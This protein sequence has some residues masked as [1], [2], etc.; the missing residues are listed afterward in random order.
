MKT[1][2]NHDMLQREGLTVIEL[3]LTLATVAVVAFVG[4]AIYQASQDVVQIEDPISPESQTQE[5]DPTEGIPEQTTIEDPDDLDEAIEELERID[6]Q[7][8]QETDDIESELEE[9]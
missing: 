5:S 9:L 6:F 1:N 2:K 3:V 4:F 7:E 8:E